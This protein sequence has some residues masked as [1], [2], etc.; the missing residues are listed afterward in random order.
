MDLEPAFEKR[1]SLSCDLML[2]VY[3]CWGYVKAHVY[4]IMSAT[5]DALDGQY[6][7]IIPE[8]P[9][10]TLESVCQNKT[11]PACVSFEMQSS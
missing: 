8:I 4:R 7:R 6:L 5:F 1:W 9:A 2:L 10:D 11:H 3:F